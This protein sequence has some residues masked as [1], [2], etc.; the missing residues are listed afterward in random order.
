MTTK[1]KIVLIAAAI[2]SVAPVAYASDNDHD[3][4]GGFRSLPN[5]AFVTDGVNSVYHQSVRGVEA[6]AKTAHGKQH[7][8]Q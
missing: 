5:G 8:N 4:N 7:I 2:L 6:H 1:T 3:Y